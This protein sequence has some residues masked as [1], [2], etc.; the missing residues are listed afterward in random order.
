MNLSSLGVQPG[1]V[2]ELY[3]QAIDRNPSLLG[4]ASSEVARIQII[5]EEDYA[6]I[7]RTR[8]TIE[9]FAERF[10]IVSESL[11]QLR[12]KLARVEKSLD[13]GDSGATDEARESALEAAAEASRLFEALAGDFAAF[14]LEEAAIEQAEGTLADLEDITEQLRSRDEPLTSEQLARMREQLGAR[15]ED[16]ARQEK[17]AEE[18]AAVSRVM[19]RAVEFSNL[20]RDQD[21]LARRLKRFERDTRARD[22]A[23][24]EAL[25]EDQDVLR[26]RLQEC[27]RALEEAIG[28]LPAGH[29]ELAEGAGALLEEVKRS[30][31][32]ADMETSSDFA[33][34]ENGAKSY[35]FS[36]LAAEK[37]NDLLEGEGAAGDFSALASNEF[38]FPAPP[39]LEKT[40]GEMLSALC[41]GMGPG[42]TPGSTPAMG[43]GS[44]AGV[45]GSSDDGYSMAGYTALDIPV[46]GPP[47]LRLRQLQPASLAGD[48]SS[49]AGGAT[50]VGDVDASDLLAVEQ[51]AY[52]HASPLDLDR[53]PEKYRAAVRRYFTPTRAESS[54]P[55][56]P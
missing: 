45:G 9:E 34:N 39:S 2:L 43:Q 32:G 30:G 41:L 40:L 47:R 13:S 23:F 21:T 55:S 10:R 42:S 24:L 35:Q 56:R 37:L 11:E 28:E 19:A 29:E 50:A 44:G 15:R 18:V 7:I 36:S 33:S 52:E 48:D 31:A 8:T 38:R 17:Q 27:T 25:G 1:E 4:V 3:F 22:V 5:S 14:D 12:Q 20:A 49:S 46:M 6:N 54:Q 26:E 53:V 16:F 51:R